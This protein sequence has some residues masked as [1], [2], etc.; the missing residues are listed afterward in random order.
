[1]TCVFCVSMLAGGCAMLGGGEEKD[2][3]ASL[4][5]KHDH[6]I[7]KN[8]DVIVGDVD[9]ER[10]TIESEYL[11]KLSVPRQQVDVLEFRGG[12]KVKLRT[13]NGDVIRGT[14][15]LKKITVLGSKLPG[16]PVIDVE[17]VRMI[18]FK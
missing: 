7:M 2:G 11:G 9:L 6:V 1:M 12:G 4:P 3:S 18:E 8:G 13:K 15:P 5:R 10:V 16:P 14:C 17:H